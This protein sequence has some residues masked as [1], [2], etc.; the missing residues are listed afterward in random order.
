MGK[1]QVLSDKAVTLQQN[2]LA[3]MSNLQMQIF[4]WVMPSSCLLNTHQRSYSKMPEPRIVHI[5]VLS[6]TL[7]LL[8][9]F[10]CVL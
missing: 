2:S 4:N 9:M 1:V 10:K 6:Q 8:D 3:P 7:K 5:S